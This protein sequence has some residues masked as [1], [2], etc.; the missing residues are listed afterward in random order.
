MRLS[1][2]YR[3]WNFVKCIILRNG[4]YFLSS[5]LSQDMRRWKQIM[6]SHS[7]AKDFHNYRNVSGFF[8]IHSLLKYLEVVIFF[9]EHWIVLHFFHWENPIYRGK[10][11]IRTEISSKRVKDPLPRFYSQNGVLR[12]QHLFSLTP[13]ILPFRYILQ[14]YV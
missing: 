12:G 5:S 11:L 6:L 1:L 13:Y 14:V 7:Q 8:W 2:N 4:S 9:K 10:V 3:E